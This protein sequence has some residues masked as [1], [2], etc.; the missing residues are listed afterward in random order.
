MTKSSQVQEETTEQPIFDLPK[1]KKPFVALFDLM[2][3]NL[4]LTVRELLPQLAALA[5]TKGGTPG[6]TPSS[7]VISDAQGVAVAIR[8]YY[9]KRFM[10]LVGDLAVEF[11]KKANTATGLNTMCKDGVSNWTKQQ[12]VARTAMSQ[13]LE[14]V[15]S[16]EVLPS[17]ISTVREE[18]TAAKER[19]K[20]TKLGFATRAEVLAY[21]VE[22]G[23]SLAKDASVQTT[24]E[25]EAEAEAEAE[26]PAKKEKKKSRR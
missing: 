26:A 15:E 8:C 23:I 25:V 22:Q 3:A 21:L 9:F 17:D 24:A 10:P 7:L 12:G 16:G 19:I 13:L 14:D 4:D 18:I 6:S 11:G 2:S 5:K 1:L 20:S